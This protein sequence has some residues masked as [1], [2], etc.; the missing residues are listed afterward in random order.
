MVLY[1]NPPWNI[2]SVKQNCVSQ[3]QVSFFAVSQE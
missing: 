3:K 1:A 2:I